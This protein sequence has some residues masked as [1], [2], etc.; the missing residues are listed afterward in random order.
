MI[1]LGILV[2]FTKVDAVNTDAAGS[3]R[4]PRAGRA[5]AGGDVERDGEPR[6]R[7]RIRAPLRRAEAARVDAAVTRRACSTAKTLNVLVLEVV[8]AVAIIVDRHRARL[9]RVRRRW[10]PRSGCCCSAPSR[11]PA[12]AC[13]SRARCAPRPTS[14]LANGLFLVLLF[15]GGMAYP[16]A[17]AAR[18]ARGVRQ[19]C[20]PPPRCRRRVRGVLDSGA[21]F[22]TGELV[23]LVVWAI[24]AP[25]RRRPLLPLGGVSGGC[26]ERLGDLR[27]LLFEERLRRDLR[28]VRAAR[29]CRRRR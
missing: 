25:A 21:S 19:G 8:Q 1:P 17:Q 4:L 18:R 10:S 22:P 23:V 9:G 20:C 14:P 5:R 24:A 29:S 2:F 7:D 27:Q 28:V 11:S 13:C 12:S 26:R 15:L 6:H 16:L 3:R